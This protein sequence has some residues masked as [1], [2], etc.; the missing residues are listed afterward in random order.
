MSKRVRDY[1]F[2][3]FIFVF[4][5]LTIFMSLYAS[6]YKFR[7]SWPLDFSRLLE[8]T[9]ALALDSQ[10]TGASVFINDKLVHASSF[11]PWNRSYQ[12][13]PAKIKNLLPGDYILRLE[14]DGYWPFEKRISIRSG[15]TTF[16]E[17]INLFR[18]AAPWLVAEGERGD[19]MIS[20]D[21]RYLYASGAAQII[22][23]KNEQATTI[24]GLASS[25][26]GVWTRSG[27]R[28]LAG[29]LSYDPEKK[30]IVDY[31]SLIGAQASSWRYEESSGYLYY[32]SGGALNRLE[33]DGKTNTT[34]LK[35]EA[36]IS[37]EPREDIIFLVSRQN[38]QSILSAYSLKDQTEKY[39]QTLPA[40][41]QYSLLPENRRLISLHDEKN[42]TL[43]LFN[44]EGLG[45]LKR[46]DGVA[47]HYWLNDEQL[48][49][50]NGWEIYWLDTKSGQSWLVT[51][52]GEAINDLAWNK[53]KDYLIFA[54]DK[55]LSTVDLANGLA[56]PVFKL[57]N[58]TFLAL[59]DRSDALYFWAS[60]GRQSG[61]YK[62]PLQ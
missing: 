56:T 13:T 44:P 36:I 4:I 42:R 20:P 31:A 50:S 48:F 55:G 53:E 19:L 16:A 39:R 12:K 45:L 41:G 17:N 60:V 30:E 8:K 38:G 15:E 40:D 9:G 27:S 46:L 24:P 3:V 47:A 29:S 2:F 23:L 7:L 26:Y 6:G 14:L 57:D 21:N 34:V 61:V 1:L 37:Y 35:N 43:Y 33:T 59:D 58:V 62:L 28:L 18:A 32:L 22:D 54:T 49:Y 5:L 51:R 11:R 10:P 25:T 52:V